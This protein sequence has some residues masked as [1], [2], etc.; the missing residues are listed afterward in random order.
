MTIDKICVSVCIA[1]CAVFFPGCGNHVGMSGK[2]TFSDDQSPLT[3]GTVFFE[4]DL[5]QAR[6]D[7]KP[8]GTYTI[9]SLHEADGLPPDTY[10]VYVVGA[11]VHNPS[12]QPGPNTP[13]V[14]L[15]LIESKFETGLTSG[16]TVN[17]DASTKNF[18]FSVDRNQKTKAKLEK[19]K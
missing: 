19:S 8:D 3:T 14:M 5:F 11:T 18:D 13:P 9:G 12:V 16:L 6:G 2:V 1:L 4:T 17:V 15:P 7:I 10:R